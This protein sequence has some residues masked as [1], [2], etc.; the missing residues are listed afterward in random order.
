VNRVRDNYRAVAF[1]LLSALLN[2]WS[3]WNRVARSDQIGLRW[4]Q[5]YLELTYAA[6]A[7]SPYEGIIKDAAA[8][9]GVPVTQAEELMQRWGE[10]EAWPETRRVLRPLGETVPLAEVKDSSIALA[11]VALACTGMSV[12][13]VVT[14]EEAGFYKPDPRPYRMVLNRLG[15]QAD[16][17]LF[18]AGS[19]SDVPGA[20]AVGMPVFWHNRMHLASLDSAVRP[21]YEAETLLPL[22][23]MFSVVKTD[24]HRES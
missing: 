17:V 8:D 12:P 1:D 3:L 23:D 13:T 6:G 18:V 9:V 21:R 22:L 10:I 2:S 5:R 11:G 24:G 19:A 14:A 20:S 7:Y 16:Q 15:L 4:R